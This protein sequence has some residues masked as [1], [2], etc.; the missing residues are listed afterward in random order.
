MKRLALGALVLVALAFG[1]LLA[2]GA[3][4]P[5]EHVASVQARFAATPEAVWALATDIE[6]HP[7]WLSMFDSVRRVEDV[8]GRPCWLYEG[9]F[10]PMP[11]VLDELGPTR[12]VTRIAPDA[13]LGYEGTWTYTLTPEA[14]GG[15]TL[16]LREDGRVPSLLFRGMGALFFDV[17]D[18]M[19][20][21]LGDLGTALGETVEPERVA[22]PE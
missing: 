14:D 10:G 9:A 7:D 20:T 21:W 17:H 12:M 8:E 1:G 22:L 6:G 3:G 15:C 13:D 16:T 5:L 4:Q 11:T 2:L 18:S 19:R